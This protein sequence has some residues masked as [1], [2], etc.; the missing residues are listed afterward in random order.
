MDLASKWDAN[1]VSDIA[2]RI[3]KL[4]KNDGKV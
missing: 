4:L 1:E 3:S 2:K